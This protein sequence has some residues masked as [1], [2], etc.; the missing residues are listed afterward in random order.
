MY[1]F[2]HEYI[3]KNNQDANCTEDYKQN[4]EKYERL[5]EELEKIKQ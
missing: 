2:I 5:K 1:E 4:K 3:R